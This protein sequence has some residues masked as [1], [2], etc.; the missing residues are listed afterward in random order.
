M[1]SAEPCSSRV[2][3]AGQVDETPS[4]S[5]TGGQDKGSEI[6]RHPCSSDANR[7]NTPKIRPKGPTWGEANDGDNA[8][9]P[10]AGGGPCRPDIVRRGPDG[11][12]CSEQLRHRRQRHA[13]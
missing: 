5:Q 12:A 4:S 1:N 9:E 6:E 13:V 7:E 2:L 3:R 11:A 8:T 10:D